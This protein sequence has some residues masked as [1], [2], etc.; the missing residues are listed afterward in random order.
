[1]RSTGS[2]K[3]NARPAKTRTKAENMTPAE[4]RLRVAGVS[5]S[6]CGQFST[7]GP[8]LGTFALHTLPC[9]R[10][11]ALKHFISV[12]DLSGVFRGDH[13]GQLFDDW[14]RPNHDAFRFLKSFDQR[15]SH[16]PY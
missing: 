4:S 5:I 11:N 13:Q 12:Y 1:M 10:S 2:A 7:G 6:P 3:I 15:G 16:G 14:G 8:P 9:E